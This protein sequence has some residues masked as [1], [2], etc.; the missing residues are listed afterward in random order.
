ML[1]KLIGISE[2]NFTSND[3]KQIEGH[4]IFVCHKDDNVTGLKTDSFF[5]RNDIKLSDVKIND[6]VNI[7][8]NSKG[9]IEAVVK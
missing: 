3:G 5:V 2:I 1:A 4:K 9:K 6:E 7:Y 8:F